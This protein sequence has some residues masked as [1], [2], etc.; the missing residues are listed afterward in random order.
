MD[1]G[2]LAR[3][4]CVSVDWF[5]IAEPLTEKPRREIESNTALKRLTIPPPR[6]AVSLASD[7]K[8]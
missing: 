2:A 7:A 6:T 3:K 8:P 5:W 1:A 4:G